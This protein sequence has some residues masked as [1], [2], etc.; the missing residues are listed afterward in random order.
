V[1]DSTPPVAKDVCNIMCWVQIKS[2]LEDCP[3][4]T[5]ELTSEE[6]VFDGLIMLA[7]ERYKFSR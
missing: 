2:H 5:S 4:R 6:H 7:K 3:Y 1:I